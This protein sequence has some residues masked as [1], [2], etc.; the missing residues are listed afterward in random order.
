[1]LTIP[2]VEQL[3]ALAQRRLNGSVRD[4]R[5]LVWNQGLILQGQTLTY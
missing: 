4:L 2:S 5:L 1:M 3:A